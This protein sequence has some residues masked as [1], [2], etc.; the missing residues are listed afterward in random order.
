M[1]SRTS[2]IASLDNIMPPSTHCSAAMSCGGVR[3]KSSRGASSAT[4]TGLHPLVAQARD[5][6]LRQSDA[7]ARGRLEQTPSAPF[8]RMV[9]TVF[10]EGTRASNHVVHKTVD[11]LCRHAGRPVRELGVKLWKSRRSPGEH[12]LLAATTPSTG[13]VHKKVS[14]HGNSSPC[15]ELSTRRMRRASSASRL[16]KVPTSG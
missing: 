15:P 5:Q 2:A 11:S 12:A 4:L 14:P 10:S 7:A 8:Y 16:S 1:T 9:L 3:S 6:P 13:C